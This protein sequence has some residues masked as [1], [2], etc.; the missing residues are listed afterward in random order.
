[1]YGSMGPVS[2]P[3][4]EWNLILV[5][6]DE[7][8]LDVVALTIGK[9]KGLNFV[10]HLKSAYNRN[11][12]IGD[13][14]NIK[15]VGTSLEEA[16]KIAPKFKMP[17]RSMSRIASLITGGFVYKV[18]KKVPIMTEKKC[19]KC[20]M[21]SEVCPAHAIDFVDGEFPV[22]NKKVCI[23]CLCCLEIC[24]HQAIDSKARGFKGLFTSY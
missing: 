19:K 20:G 22:F 1:M 4:K 7:L 23:S 17:R 5:G 10:P 9:F 16:K 8:A 13:L 3:M 2:G 6:T 21:C 24:P 14:E 15:I 11:L 18:T 12:G